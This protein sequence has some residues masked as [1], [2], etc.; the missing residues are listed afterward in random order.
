MA[1]KNENDYIITPKD[2]IMY[3]QQFNKLSKENQTTA[4]DVTVSSPNTPFSPY[5]PNSLKTNSCSYVT[6]EQCMKYFQISELSNQD[7][8]EIWYLADIDH[9]NSLIRE[10]FYIAMHLIRLKKNGSNLPEILPDS[11]IPPTLEQRCNYINISLKYK[12]LII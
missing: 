2:M 9:N 6:N 5:T 11:L 12:S 1:S 4:S 7:L 8:E 10:E 3:D